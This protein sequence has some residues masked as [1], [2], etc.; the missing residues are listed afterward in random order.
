MS[1]T[2]TT[3]HSFG[4]ILKKAKDGSYKL[5]AFQRKWRWTTRQVMSLY[6]SLRLGYPIG[7]FLFLTSP[8]GAKLDPRAFHGSGRRA[9]S[10]AEH[11]SLVL[12]GQ[13]RITAGMTIYYGLDD[14]DG[15]EYYVDSGKIN[16]LLAD[17]KVNIED[18]DA[19][20][21][22]CLQLDL[23]DGYL[24]PKPRRL[25]RRSH[26]A[27]R[28]LV[29]TAFLTEERQDEFDELVDGIEDRRKKDVMRKVVRKF[30]KPSANVQ[31]PVI[32]LGSDFDLSSIS[33]VFSTINSSGKLL[34]PFELVVAILYP[35]GVRLEEDIKDF[36]SRFSYYANMDRGGEVLLQTIALMSKRS[37]KKAE[38]PKTIE[39]N[40]YRQYAEQAADALDQAG[41]FLT[42]S[43]GIGLDVTDR[44]TPYDALFAPFALVLLR[45]KEKKISVAEQGRAQRKLQRWFVASSIIQRYQEGVHNKQK[46]DLEEM[47][48]WIDDDARIPSWIE[49]TYV[50]PS[51]KLASPNG[52][53]G[54]LLTCLINRN[55][56]KDPV[57]GGSIGYGDQL[58]TTQIHHI[59][60]TKWV[61][62]GLKNAGSKKIDSNIALNTMLLHSRTNGDW[63][64][65][66]PR[67][68]I[69]QSEGAI[70]REAMVERYKSQLID[71]RCIELMTVSDK[72]VQDYE[73][74]L[75]SRYR[76]LI[77]LL[78]QFDI[79]ES[80][81]SAD[82]VELDEP[83]IEESENS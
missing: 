29:W 1:Q 50:T 57:L 47:N 35:S 23:D 53:I 3:A 70:G 4:G 59:Y 76:V 20:R 73:D 7:A 17:H 71:D 8:E 45:L 62:K 75:D 31:V 67:S 69:E 56:P 12:D 18:E 30:L 79:N 60:P 28:E 40:N 34:T 80:S 37:P 51:I 48:A 66:D 11:D 6:E 24:V 14:V 61:S 38:L 68:Q 63:L 36:K 19:V 33:K 65:F 72:S 81:D 26:F 2:K 21:Q 74:F 78:R 25:D 41:R 49:N 82:L 54:R 9:S 46:Q 77:G 39:Q 55:R 13:Q 10:H 58:G 16:T 52:A 5:P 27:K 22:F 83:S 15:A 64:N 43:M 32:E 44:L 42:E